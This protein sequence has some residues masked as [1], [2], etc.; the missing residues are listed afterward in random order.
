MCVFVFVLE[1]NSYNYIAGELY[2]RCEN[3]GK[4]IINYMD[5]DKL[6]ENVKIP[7]IQSCKNYNYL[8]FHWVHSK[9]HKE[10]KMSGKK[11]KKSMIDSGFRII[12]DLRLNKQTL[13]D[14]RRNQL[15][16]FRTISFLSYNWKKIKELL[17]K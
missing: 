12:E 8:K 17:G 2:N 15:R 4:V 5:G 3:D 14:Q 9:W 6:D 7:N 11:L 1:K 10:L 13:I 16:K